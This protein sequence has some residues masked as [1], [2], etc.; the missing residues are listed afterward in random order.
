M[1]HA[2]AEHYVEGV[3]GEWQAENTALPQL[4]VGQ[5]SQCQPGAD[6][7]NGFGGQVTPGPAGPISYQAP[8]RYRHLYR[9]SQTHQGNPHRIL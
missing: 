1:Q 4:V 7:V 2:V 8:A 5:A 9:N 6:S 3:I